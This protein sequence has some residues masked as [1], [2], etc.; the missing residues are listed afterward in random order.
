MPWNK[1]KKF[2]FFNR[3]STPVFR[4]CKH[5]TTVNSFWM[6]FN[7]NDESLTAE[8]W[9]WKICN[10]IRTWEM[11]VKMF[12]SVYLLLRSQCLVTMSGKWQAF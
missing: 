4:I 1:W 12:D 10:V 2:S 8:F 11:H 3:N 9:R 7:V 6:S 5:E